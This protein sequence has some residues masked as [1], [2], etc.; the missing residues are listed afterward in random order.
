MSPDDSKG[1]GRHIEEQDRRHEIE[2]LE[3]I[4]VLIS[5]PFYVKNAVSH[6]VLLFT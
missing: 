1:G 4:F 3:N 5:F 6:V 2:E